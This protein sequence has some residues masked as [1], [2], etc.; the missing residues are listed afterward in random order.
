MIANNINFIGVK[1]LKKSLKVK[2]KIRYSSPLAEA[3]I[4]PLNKNN[5]HVKFA[6]SQWAITPGQSVVFYDG[7]SVLGGGIIFKGLSQ[8]NLDYL[9]SQI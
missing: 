5:L 9:E 3:S 2:A 8:N 4:F 1:D 6:R 7:D